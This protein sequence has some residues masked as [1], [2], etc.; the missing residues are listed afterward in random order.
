M[1]VCVGCL[2]GGGDCFDLDEPARFEQAGA[3]HCASRMVIAEVSLS[4]AT[5]AGSC[6]GV[7]R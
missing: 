5:F 7:A 4:T 1:W 6:A 2:F 3:H